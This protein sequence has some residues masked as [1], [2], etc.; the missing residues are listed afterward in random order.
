MTKYWVQF[1]NEGVIT[2]QLADA[3]GSD[4]VAMLDGRMSSEN[5]RREA[6]K[7]AQRLQHVRKF[8]AFQLCMGP[9]YL[10]ESKRGP[11]HKLTYPIHI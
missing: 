6:L 11:V 4:Q 5:M 2:K 8:A 3:T 1:L 7:V 10:K 9:Q